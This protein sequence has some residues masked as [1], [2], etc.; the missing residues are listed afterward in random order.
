MKTYLV[1]YG[2]KQYT[3]QRELLKIMAEVSGF[4][5]EV[6]VFTPQD[7]DPQFKH[8]FRDILNCP[9]G[10]GY[11]IWKPWLM[12]KMF[13]VL[14][15]DDMLVYCDAGCTIN[16]HGKE[17][18]KQYLELVSDSDTGSLGFELPHKEIEYTKQEVIEYFNASDEILKSDQLMA[19]SVI[20]KKCG[21][22]DFLI[23]KW[24]QTLLEK[25]S[26]FT[27]A[28]DLTIQNNQFIDHRHDQSVFSVIRKIYGSEVI[29]DDT[30]FLDFNKHGMLS[31]IWATRRRG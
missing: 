7:L 31:P 3:H 12:H 23:E 24:Y 5:D 1:T 14:H 9:R 8:H 30:Y 11:W 19:T 13:N 29:P 26:L 25:P 27:D 10:G 15:N 21:H 17:R 20:L 4:F 16:S 18:F 28:K 22:A 2:D 6:H